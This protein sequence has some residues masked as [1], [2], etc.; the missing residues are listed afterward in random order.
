MDALAQGFALFFDIVGL[1]ELIDATRRAGF[2][3]DPGVFGRALCAAWLVGCTLIV[4][5]RVV[6]LVLPSLGLPLR[7]AACAVT[8]MWLATAGFHVLR[9][10]G[11]FSLLGAIASV[12]LLLA[13]AVRVQPARAPWRWVLTRELRAVRRVLVGCRRSPYGY[14]SGLLGAYIALYT[15]RALSVPPLGWDT[16]TYH[17]PRAVTWLASQQLSFDPGPG[18]YSLYRHYVSGGEVLVAW[19]MLPFHSDL[20]ANAVGV[21]SWVVCGVATWAAARAIPIGEPFAAASGGLTCLMPLLAHATSSGYVEPPLYAATLTG[22]ACAFHALRRRVAPPLLVIGSLAVGLAIGMKLTV[23]PLGGLALVVL[24]GRFLVA[25]ASPLSALQAAGWCAAAALV[26]AAP[27]VPWMLHAWHETGYPLSPLPI[28]VLGVSL[29]VSNPELTWYQ[30][31]PELTPY[32]WTTEGA[33]LEQVFAELWPIQPGVGPSL[34]SLATIPLLASLVGVGALLRRRKPLTAAF[35][36]LLMA[37]TWWV[38]FSPGLSV[39]RLLWS[40]TFS[41]FMI[42][43]VVIAG[44]LGF[45][46]CT[47]HSRLA[48][49]YRRLAMFAAL[50]PA[51]MTLT[52][53]FG[54]W[55]MHEIAAVGCSLLAVGWMAHGLWTSRLVLGVRCAALA[56]LLALGCS[57]LQ[58]RRDQTRSRAYRDS[59]A[60]HH[61]PRHW[62]NVAQ[63]LDTLNTPHH[64]AITGGP[65]QNGDNWLH[66]FFYGRRFQNTITYVTPTRDGAIP[67]LVPEHDLAAASDFGRGRARLDTRHI[68]HVLT[69]QPRSLEQTWMEAAPDHFERLE[70]DEAWGVYRVKR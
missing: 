34:G 6:R 20:F 17:G 13:A 30:T 33:A 22:V 16:L 12:T 4:S 57:A 64:L 1:R 39:V 68:D 2:W 5:L 37:A 49:G 41:R 56:T 31:H 8:G 70:G 58:L 54:A 3:I 23:L 44:V 46:W 60:L 25:P 65:H 53:G 69:F 36:G 66:Y 21:A 9:S 48:Q 55:E 40:T 43:L 42:P 10:L 7:W 52:Y 18:P 67:H 28:R 63:R 38:Y 35:G 47:P 24:L 61:W 26:T 11:A 29:G 14:A 15:L 51:A 50:W 45:A 19:A 62:V 59:F 27:I 32:R